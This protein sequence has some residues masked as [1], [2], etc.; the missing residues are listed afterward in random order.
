[1]Q[2]GVVIFESE[3]QVRPFD[4]KKPEVKTSQSQ[5]K[6]EVET[7]VNLN[8]RGIPISET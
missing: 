8:K 4:E 2:N 6:P 1:M 5:S 7:I 3:N